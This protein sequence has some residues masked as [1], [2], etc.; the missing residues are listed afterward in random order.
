MCGIWYKKQSPHAE[1]TRLN[2]TKLNST[3]YLIFSRSSLLLSS[4]SVAR[5]TKKSYANNYVSTNNSDFLAAS[6]I[7]TILEIIDKY[8]IELCRIL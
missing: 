6:E 2:K 8:S 3:D 5:S 4:S 7:F 1:L